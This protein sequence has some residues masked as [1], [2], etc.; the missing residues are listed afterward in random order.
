MKGGTSVILFS[1]VGGLI[2]EV[3]GDGF[4]KEHYSIL[5]LIFVVC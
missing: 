5:N 3:S 1:G 2:L 4:F